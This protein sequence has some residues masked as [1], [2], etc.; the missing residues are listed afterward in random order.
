MGLCSLC[1]TV[2]FFSLP[3]FPTR[4]EAYMKPWDGTDEL[5]V[6]VNP[7]KAQARK[8]GE[9]LTAGDFSQAL[10][11]SHHQSIQELKSA[12][13]EDC[14]IC[15]IILR[16][17]DRCLAAF[18]EA[19]KD[20]QYIYYRDLRGSDRPDFRLWLCKRRDGC[21]GFMVLSKAA[22]GKEKAYLLAG[23]GF[24][25][26]DDDPLSSLIVGRCI[27]EDP[28]G[29][30][31]ISR[32]VAWVRACDD[33]HPG[34][35]KAEET[36]LPLRVLDVDGS[37]DNI[38]LH[39]TTGET[40][41]YIAL[42]H[43]WG[44]NRHFI[45]TKQNIAAH[46]EGI[47]LQEL[48]KTFQDAVSMTRKLG[49]RYL[50]ID[51]LCIRQDDGPDWERQ[52]ATMAS[53]YANAYITIAAT[54]SSDDSKGF[55]TPRSV[56]QY[57]QFDCTK[58]GVTGTVQAFL[59]KP[60]HAANAYIHSSLGDEPLSGRGWALQERV[61]AARTLHFASDQMFFECYKHFLGEDGFKIGGRYHTVYDDAKPKRGE[62]DDTQ[63]SRQFRG[64]DLWYELLYAYWPRNLTNGSDKLPAVSGIART[65]ETLTGDQYVAGLWRSQ[66]IEGLIW[67]AMGTHSGK[68]KAPSEY[69]APSW[70]WASFDGP[71]GN[72]GLG[73]N[74]FISNAPWMDIATVLDCKV[75]LKG[76]N[77]YGEVKSGWLKVRAP[78]EP[79][80]RSEELE[81]DWQTAPH[82]RATRLTTRNGDN[83]GSFAMFDT[84]DDDLALKLPLSA[85]L[86][87]QNDPKDDEPKKQGYQA[88]LITPVEEEGVDVFKRVGKILFDGET[89]GDCDWMND[90]MQMRTITLI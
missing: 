8:A 12:A 25:V 90:P 42:S 51:S 20:E 60:V 77:P 75:E 67:Q 69:R 14:P 15:S 74:R 24:C 56:P 45:T 5:V 38:R 72:L 3:S 81:K 17:V 18:A 53:I 70:S 29:E 11:L 52:S 16:S 21:D 54:G 66:I 43:V 31:T 27:H 10:G 7:R 55:L 73:K 4:Y 37:S 35:C 83:F 63:L 48:P 64:P 78:I 46:K 28:V 89:L 22:G 84:L 32:A 47:V 50:W 9:D 86:L 71:F 40:A 26:E 62:E 80:K 44:E 2:D 6:F 58:E 13:E 82:K 30:R 49:V 88:L 85:L 65:F 68:T 59:I 76:D 87:V 23:V 57:T 19:E 1:Q 33:S 61:L 36:E 34:R 41:R 79:L 39:E